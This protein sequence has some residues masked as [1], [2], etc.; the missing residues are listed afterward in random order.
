[1]Q[2]GGGLEN[3][4]MATTATEVIRQWIQGLDLV[5]EGMQQV[6]PEESRKEWQRLVPF[7][8]R[9]FQI[10]REM[11]QRV[12]F[13]DQASLDRVLSSGLALPLR[14]LVPFG[15]V[16][17]TWQLKCTLLVARLAVTTAVASPLN[18]PAPSHDV[19]LSILKT[20]AA[21]FTGEDLQ[22]SPCKHPSSFLIICLF[23]YADTR[24]PPSFLAHGEVKSQ[25]QQYQM[26][27]MAEEI[28][29]LVVEQTALPQKILTE[30]MVF[31]KVSRPP[32]SE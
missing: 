28:V 21:I 20:A 32:M 9:S 6:L 25:Q 22:C 31:V 7:I 4:L 2:D 24:Y 5:D 18:S 26:M 8:V 3:H 1:M 19:Y 29:R 12:T 11:I 23:V 30:A 15:D 13:S 27:M 17:A 10:A 16:A 14:F